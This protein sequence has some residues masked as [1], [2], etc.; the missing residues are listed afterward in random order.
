[1]ILD[2]CLYKF[3]FSVCHVLFSIVIAFN[4]W[5]PAC[6]SVSF[7]C[8]EREKKR[9]HKSKTKEKR[10]RIYIVKSSVSNTRTGSDDDDVS[11][12]LIWN[13][14]NAYCVRFLC[15]FLLFFYSLFAWHTDVCIQIRHSHVYSCEKRNNYTCKIKER[16]RKHA[17]AI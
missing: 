1:M 4:I 12:V 7:L 11:V 2:A 16:K 9:I 8:A 5:L 14:L 10:I 17:K 13:H 3:M 6:N 15:Y